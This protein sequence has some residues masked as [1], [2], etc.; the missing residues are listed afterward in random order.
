MSI[1]RSLL[2]GSGLLL[3]LGGLLIVSALGLPAQA[4]VVVPNVLETV[5]GNNNNVI[6][7]NCLS[8]GPSM[9]YQQ[10]YS[11]LEVGTL[12]IDLI[13][14]RLDQEFPTSH[15]ELILGATIRLSST[16][17]MPDL[18]SPIFADNLGPDAAVV[19][20]GDLDLSSA[21]CSGA[22][23]CP[24]DIRIPLDVGF[25]FAGSD[26]D[27]LLLDVS[28][29]V[30]A[31]IETAGIM[32]AEATTG[33]SISRAYAREVN[34]TVAEGIDTLGLVTR[35]APALIFTDGFESG[36]TTAW[37]ST[38]PTPETAADAALGS[39]G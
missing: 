3:G 18:M 29:P 15:R 33:D 36:D 27:N 28:L 32:D 26:A 31:D 22:S 35:F 23:V 13:F 30:C 8:F 17:A 25:S 1:G 4:Q 7:F 19:Y 6:P 11:G 10:V 9:R 2:N 21:D 5:E 14:F 38:V 37:S 12:D 20:S 39:F 24:F 16:T 34:A